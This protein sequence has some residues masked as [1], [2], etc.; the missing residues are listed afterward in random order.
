MSTSVS[1]AQQCAEADG[2]RETKRRS[3]AQ[4]ST[5]LRSGAGATDGEMTILKDAASRPRLFEWV[6]APEPA[7]LDR[8]LADHGLEMPD[9]LVAF[10]RATGGGVA[11][12]ERATTPARRRRRPRRQPVVEERVAPQSG[13]ARGFLVVS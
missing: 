11:V 9:D 5:D 10:W 3:L 2:A 13:Y 12:R 4:C 8:W 1:D 6:G 7:V